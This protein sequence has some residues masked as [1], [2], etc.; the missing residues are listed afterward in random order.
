M[1][2]EGPKHLGDLEAPGGWARWGLGI[3]SWVEGR[4]C[5]PHGPTWHLARGSARPKDAG[6]KDFANKPKLPRSSPPA[7]R[8]GKGQVSTP[9]GPERV[10]APDWT[11][12]P[13]RDPGKLSGSLSQAGWGG[14]QLPT[15]A[16]K[17]PRNSR[18]YPRDGS[19]RVRH[20]TPEHPPDS[21]THPSRPPA[22]TPSCFWAAMCFAQGRALPQKF[23]L[24]LCILKAPTLQGTM[25]WTSSAPSF[26]K[27]EACL[28][29][30]HPSC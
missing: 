28:F 8:Q 30:G 12:A 1:A 13:T 29:L 14:G 6:G 24:G 11:P 10:G 20:P 17:Q 23:P 3:T 21:Q 9:G 4:A 27:P 5:L 16:C 25:V 7:T 15:A 22:P 19:D 18:T 2:A 26:P